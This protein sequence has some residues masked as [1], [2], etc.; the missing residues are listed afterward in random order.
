MAIWSRTRRGADAGLLAHRA[1]TA[2][3]RGDQPRV[4]T[5][6][7]LE[8]E[9]GAVRIARG[10]DHLG[11]RHQFDRRQAASRRSIAARRKRFSTIQP[12]GADSPSS[13]S[14]AMIE[15]QEQ[16]ARPAIVAG[17]GNA[18]VEDRLGLV[19]Q[20]VQTPTAAK[21]RWLV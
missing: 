17:I 10:L 2:F 8:D 21:R 15:M 11:R 19:R 5:P 1:E 13:R 16:R 20:S 12:I 9:L 18:D 4:E 3:G 7:A 6:A 14:L